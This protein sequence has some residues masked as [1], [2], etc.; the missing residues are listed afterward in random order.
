MSETE[1]NTLPLVTVVVPAYNHE[2]YIEECVNSILG[3]DYPAIELFVIN[4]GSTDGTNDKMAAI[5]KKYP[6]RIKYINKENEGLITSLNIALNE[7]TGKYYCELASDDSWVEG[8]LKKRV[9][10]LESNKEYD[11]VFGDICYVI[12]GEKT[13]QRLVTHVKYGGYDSKI[14]DVKHLLE[15][16]RMIVFPTGLFKREALLELGGFDTDFRFF[17]DIAMRYKLVHNKKVGYIDEP[18]VWYR[19]HSG[20][21]SHVGEYYIKMKEESILTFEKFSGAIEGS[22][23]KTL[24]DL[25]N[26]KLF[27]RYMGYVKLGLKNKLDKEKVLT[28]IEKAI[29]LKPRSIMARLYKFKVG[30]SL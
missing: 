16:K 12:D 19:K 15:V 29:K 22:G 25:L 13:A 7:G 27:K 14:H 17:E 1:K 26:K 4:D 5:C 9:E 24:K 2:G 18:L 10:F 6:G 28:V 11:A 3:Q 23:D 21:V 20:N 30:L 8:S